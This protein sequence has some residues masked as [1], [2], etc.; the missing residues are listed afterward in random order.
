MADGTTSSD[1]LDSIED[2]DEAEEDVDDLEDQVVDE[3]MATNVATASATSV[4]G[5]YAAPKT[6]S[7][8]RKPWQCRFEETQTHKWEDQGITGRD[9]HGDT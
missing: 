7:R 6:N 2:Y 3:D 5:F 8:G 1:Q 9:A 4:V